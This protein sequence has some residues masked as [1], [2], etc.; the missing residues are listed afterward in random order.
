MNALV[1][2][3]HAWE[4]RQKTAMG[5][6]HDITALDNDRK[7]SQGALSCYHWDK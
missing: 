3:I 4:E 7:R 2:G 1:P 5:L 6:C